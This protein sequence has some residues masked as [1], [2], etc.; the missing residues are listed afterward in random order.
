[1]TEEEKNYLKETS[2]WFKSSTGKNYLNGRPATAGEVDKVIVELEK[3]EKARQR[4]QPKQR[5]IISGCGW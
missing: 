3:Q 1:M 2:D 5:P 4:N